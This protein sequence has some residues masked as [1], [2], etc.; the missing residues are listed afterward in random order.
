VRNFKQGHHAG[1][2]ISIGTDAFAFTS[3]ELFFTEFYG[4]DF[5]LF[6]MPDL[7]AVAIQHRQRDCLYQ[8]NRLVELALS[9]SPAL[10]IC[11]PLTEER[12]PE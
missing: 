8:P 2:A 6:D 4:S 10:P 9:P 11:K 1:N 12:K 5:L 7:F 3:V